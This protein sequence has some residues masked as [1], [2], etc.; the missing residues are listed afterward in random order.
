MS[1]APVSERSEPLTVWRAGLDDP[2]PAVVKA[3]TLIEWQ[4]GGP[5]AWEH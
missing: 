2:D 1:C 3:S 4:G 5:D